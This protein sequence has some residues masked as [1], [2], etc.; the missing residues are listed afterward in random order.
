MST[1]EDTLIQSPLVAIFWTTYI[2]F[3]IAVLYLVGRSAIRSLRNFRSEP[4]TKRSWRVDAGPPQFGFL[5]RTQPFRSA[6]AWRAPLG[7]SQ[8]TQQGDSRP[9]E[10]PFL[11]HGYDFSH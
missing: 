10:S 9:G 5:E 6:Y 11:I 7:A 3:V 4:L 2:P 1:I 8:Q